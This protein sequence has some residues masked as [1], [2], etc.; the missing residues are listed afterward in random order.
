MKNAQG[1]L[2]DF[3]TDGTDQHT[4][5]Y[6]RWVVD[7]C[8]PLNTCESKSFIRMMTGQKKNYK[9]LDR[10]SV[11]G[12]V[13]SV[14]AIVLSLMVLMCFGQF[15]AITSDHWSSPADSSF[16]AITGHF[17]N[18]DWEMVSLTLACVEHVGRSTSERCEEELGK[19]LQKYGLTIANVVALVTDTEAT[20]TRLG[21]ITEGYHHYCL[22]HLLELVTVTYF[23]HIYIYGCIY[24]LK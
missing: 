8:K 4:I 2:D 18:N 6:L 15:L 17:I 12:K 9:S 5:D 3:L 16:L 11:V 13:A 7:E 10:H 1:S 24:V 14:T 23:E 19:A 21:N 22:A 20:M